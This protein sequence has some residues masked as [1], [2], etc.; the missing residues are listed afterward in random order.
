MLI[1]EVGLN[2]FGKL[3]EA[4][5]ILQKLLETKID[6]VTFQIRESKF[7]SDKFENFSLPISTYKELSEIT[8]SAGKKFGLAISDASLIDIMDPYCD[9]FKILSKDIGNR[10]ILNIFNNTSSDTEIF[11]ST[12]N[13]DYFEIK[14]ASDAFD[15]NITLI[16][17][18]LSNEVGDVNLKSMKIMKIL[19]P[20]NKIAFGNHCRNLNVMYASV[21]FDPSDYFFYVKDE[22]LKTPPDDLHAIRLNEVDKFCENITQLQKA[23]GD[24]LRNKTKNTIEGQL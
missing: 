11:L 14:E 13:S 9:F 24:G 8:R 17:T 21:G 5:N 3:F 15:R 12:G 2:H 20:N 1:A 18:R 22:E 10:E 6:A 7:Y 23:V 4:F 19:F 16:H